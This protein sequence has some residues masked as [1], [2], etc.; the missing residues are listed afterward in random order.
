MTQLIINKLLRLL[1]SLF[2]V[3]TLTFFLMH[4]IP[5]DPFVQEQMIPEEILLSMRKH[6]GLDQPL[7][8]QYINYLKNIAYLDFGPSFKYEGVS[9]SHIIFSS[10]PISLKIGSIA[11]GLASVFGVL[12]GSLAAFFRDKWQDFFIM[13]FTI[14]GISIP[15]FI[16]ATLLQY[17]FAMKLG[18][19]PIARYGTLSHL[20]LPSIS[21]AAMPMMF[22][23]KLTRATMVDI[24]SK[25]YILVAKS[26]GLS[27]TIIF[28]RHVL[29]NS[30][31]PV[32][33]F[34]GNM[35]A[36][37]LVGSFVIEKIFG[38]PGL[39]SWY[40]NAIASRDYTLIMGITIFYSTI[41]I[42]AVMIADTVSVYLD[43]RTSKKRS[44]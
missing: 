8:I 40:V 25:E 22:I 21:L 37:I 7:Y 41:L 23:A 28:F 12:L 39:G 33:A 35:T 11:L 38:I 24:L 34:I 16:L 31:I 30:L 44:G 27:N 3:I 42:T 5:G 13:S 2:T 15:S 1:L 10:F 6:Y 4:L 20:V 36:S 18:W 32:I 19:F 29:K 43:P 9:V 17:V 26:K 14:I